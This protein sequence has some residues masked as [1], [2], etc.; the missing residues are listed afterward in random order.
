MKRTS[1][2]LPRR[3]RR[4][5]AAPGRAEGGA[6]EARQGRDLGRRPEG[7]RGSRD[8][9]RHPQAGRG[10]AEGRDRRRIPPL[11]V[12]SRFPLGP[13][14]GRAPRD[15]RRRRV[16][17]GQDTRRRHQGHRQG[18]L[19]RPSDDRALQVRRRAHQGDA[20][21][22]HSGAVRD[23]RPP[24]ADADRQEGLSGPRLLL[25]RR[26]PGLP[27]GGARLRGRRLPLPAARRSVHRDAVRRKISPADARPR[28][29]SGKARRDLWRPDQRRDVGHPF[30]HDDHDAHVPRQLQIHLHGRGRLRRRAGDPVQQDQRARL[31]HGVRR[32]A[33]R[34]LRAAAHA[35]EGQAGRA[36][37]RH[38]QDRQARKQG[39]PEAPHRRGREIRPA[40][41]ALPVRPV[42]LRVD[43]GRQHADRGRAMGQAGPRSWKWRR[44][45]LGISM[46]RTKPPFRADHVGSFLRT[47][48]IKQARQKREKRR[49]HGRGAQGDR[50]RRDQEDHRQTGRVRAEARHRRRVP[51]L[52]VALRF[53]LRSRRR[54]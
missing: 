39:R 34:R 4:Q 36:R 31:F 30:R 42:R 5:P 37:P 29:R 32:R 15:G 53:P 27:Q 6:R 12:A 47:A 8:R 48:P 22:H 1:T 49:D 19:L 54:A 28:R 41:S 23:L 25:P 26:R 44:R 13:R 50:G 16:R 52:L 3:P 14:R 7:D 51:P 18:R 33:L 21:D 9:A 17:G 46:Q 2:A 43:R 45:G 24:D 11:L 35:A 40:R 20:E 38:H 10:R